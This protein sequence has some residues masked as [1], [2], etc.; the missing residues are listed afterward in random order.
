MLPRPLANLQ[1]PY[2]LLRRAARAIAIRTWEQ[3]AGDAMVAPGH[4]PYQSQSVAFAVRTAEAFARFDA[5]DSHA[6]SAPDADKT[7]TSC[8][9]RHELTPLH[10]HAICTT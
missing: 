3:Q 5:S 1:Q 6:L 10:T 4:H 8:Q 2:L 9:V 7:A